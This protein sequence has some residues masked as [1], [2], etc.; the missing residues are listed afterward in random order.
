[1]MDVDVGI[2]PKAT[3]LAYE[4]RLKNIGLAVGRFRFADTG[5]TLARVGSGWTAHERVQLAF[6]GLAAVLWLGAVVLIPISRDLEI[7]RLSAEAASLRAPA[8]RAS[9]IRAEL[10]HMQAPV[11]AASARQ[12]QLDALDALRAVTQ[13]LPDDVQL[14][15]FSLQRGLIGMEG[16]AEDPGRV[17]TLL[18]KSAYFRGA[19]L[20]KAPSGA[21]F[22]I[23]MDTRPIAPGSGR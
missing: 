4:E 8:A 23:E 3:L 6:A 17:V 18:N 19:H 5:L 13:L 22:V 11:S 10:I 14:S 1:M 9:A 21:Q 2:V 12:A 16:R 7:D 20:T 15:S